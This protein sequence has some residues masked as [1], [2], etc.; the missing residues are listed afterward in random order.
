MRDTW[1]FPGA[2]MTLSIMVVSTA[3]IV[4]CSTVPR[5]YLNQAE[6]GVTLTAVIADPARYQGKVVMLGGALLGEERRDG[7]YWLHLRNRPLDK[8]NRP[9]LPGERESP[10]GGTY[11]VTVVDRKEFPA[12][13]RHWARMTVVGRVVGWRNDVANDRR[14]PVMGMLYIRG[15]GLNSAHDGEWEQ[16]LDPNYL[17]SPPPILDQRGGR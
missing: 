6:P 14:E 15:W 9:H 4:G 11:W 3:I 10:E 12:N 8:E 5:K 16:R 17:V 2:G 1:K 13:Y 7:H